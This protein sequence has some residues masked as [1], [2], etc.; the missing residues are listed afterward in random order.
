[1]LRAI[2]IGALYFLLFF[3]KAAAQSPPSRPILFVHGFCDNASGW[4]SL[5][6]ANS[7]FRQNLPTG[8]YTNGTVYF[9]END[10]ATLPVG[11]SAK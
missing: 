7:A 1:M 9:V 10:W 4:A 5:F 3:S 8:L 11:R 2:L 6:A